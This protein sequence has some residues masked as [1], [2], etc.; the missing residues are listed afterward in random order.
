LEEILLEKL[1]YL[2][3][4]VPLANL[5]MAG[6]VALNCV[7]N[8]RIRQQGPF[9][10]LFVQPAAGDAGGCLGAAALA[11]REL[12]GGTLAGLGRLDQVF[13][14]PCYA[15]R[16]VG[17]LLEALGVPATDYRGRIGDLLAM[18]AARLASG[19]VLG[20]FHGRMEF[21]PRALGA[22]SIL[23][24]PRS[25]TMRQRVNASVKKREDFR[26]FA[27]SVLLEYASEYFE[28]DRPSPFMLETC[29]VRAPG[30]PAVTHVDGSARPQTVTAQQAPRYRALLEAFHRLTGCPVLLNT[31]LNVRGEPLAGSP[32]DAVRCL[33]RASLDALV[34]EDFLVEGHRIPEELRRQVLTAPMAESP[35][36]LVYT[37]T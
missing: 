20:W 4:A 30:L 5:C 12:T 3:D 9:K 26:P 27:P 25:S 24:D 34:L 15:S 17:R 23:A 32:M 13:L 19:Q 21:G 1:E 35:G 8:R 31:S 18:T 36:A 10:D 7:A 22:R 6:G 11:Y 28:L 37:F 29:G 2:H 33:V 16:D 14:G